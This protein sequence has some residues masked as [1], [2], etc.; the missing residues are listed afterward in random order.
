MGICAIV[1]INFGQQ[2]LHTTGFSTTF[3]DT[4]FSPSALLS[5]AIR[6]VLGVILLRYMAKHVIEQIEKT[7][8]VM[9][10]SYFWLV[11]VV[12]WG[13]NLY[14]LKLW[15]RS[16]KMQRQWEICIPLKNLN[17]CPWLLSPL[18][19]L[20]TLLLSLSTNPCLLIHDW[21]ADGGPCRQ[22]ILS[23][24]AHPCSF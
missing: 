1:I 17:G 16:V 14:L 23:G 10:N 18:S 8:L 21:P 13:L 5:D 22:R 19:L 6:Y 2:A 7:E 4:V 9:Y 11:A 12:M 15:I 24:V 3:V 20:F